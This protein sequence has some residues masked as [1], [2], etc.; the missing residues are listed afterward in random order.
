MTSPVAE[1]V[2]PDPKAAPNLGLPIAEVAQ[3]TGLSK[4]TLRYHEE[5]GLVEAVDR[6]ELLTGYRDAVQRHIADLQGDLQVRDTK[7]SHYRSLLDQQ[8]GTDQP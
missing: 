7:T 5:A 6:F 4:D 1:P 2:D 3:R 8:I